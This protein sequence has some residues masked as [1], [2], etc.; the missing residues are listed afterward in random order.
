MS[1]TTTTS[2]GPSIRSLIKTSLENVVFSVLFEQENARK[3]TNKTIIFSF[4]CL[5]LHKQSLIS[6]YLRKIEE[7]IK[8]KTKWFIYDMQE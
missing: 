3:P 1:I 6:M 2:I 4:F 7:H 8:K 5:K